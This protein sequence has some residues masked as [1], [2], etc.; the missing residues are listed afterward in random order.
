MRDFAGIDLSVEEVPDATTLL[1]FRHLLERHKLG[2]AIFERLNQLLRQCGLL[3]SQGT[4]IDAT[5]IAAPCSTKNEKKERDP[6]MGHTRKGKQYYFGLKSHIGADRD[7]GLVHTTVT[8]AA[9]VADINQTHNLLH[10][11]EK[12]AHTDAGYTGAPKREELK[13]KP[14]NWHIAL[15]R[16]QIKKMPEGPEK[17]ALRA[18]EKAKAQIRA[19]IEHPFHIIKNIFKHRK[20]RYRGIDKN[21][22]QLCAL[23][24]LVNLYKLRRSAQPL[25]A[26]S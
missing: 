6:E 20:V 8:T 24:T 7:S 11:Q 13:D 3:M 12:E 5:I 19:L 1:K 25:L 2:Q 16:G 17:D 21:H 10:G 22:N 4:M 14:I 15:R 9:N 23:Y 18:A 26:S